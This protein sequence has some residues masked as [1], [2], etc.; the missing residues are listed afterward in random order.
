LQ[1]VRIAALKAPGPS[2]MRPEHLSELIGVHRRRVANRL[3]R[4]LGDL[5]DAVNGGALAEEARWMTRS[6]TIRLEKKGSCMPRPIKVG[7]VLRA[8]AAKRLLRSVG[9]RLRAH[10]VGMRQWGVSLPGGAEALAHWRQTVED[11]ARQGKIDP[12]VVADLEMAIFSIPSN[13]APYGTRSASTCPSP[14]LP[15]TGRTKNQR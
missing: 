11:A 3:L 7:E 14:L 6:R 1:G 10:F 12:V 5:L 9:P 2:G 13:G 8:A 15:C 4:F